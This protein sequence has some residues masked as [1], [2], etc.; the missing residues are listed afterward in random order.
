MNKSNNNNNNKSSKSEK[1]YKSKSYIIEIKKENRT[2]TLGN[3]LIST[4][5]RRNK[6]K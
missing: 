1:K 5:R 4:I 2:T 3:C 6:R